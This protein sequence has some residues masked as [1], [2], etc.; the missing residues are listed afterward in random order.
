MKNTVRIYRPELTADE[1]ARRMDQIKQA[2][3]E[4]LRAADL[5]HKAKERAA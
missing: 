5:A 3:A 1:R 4:L 2:A